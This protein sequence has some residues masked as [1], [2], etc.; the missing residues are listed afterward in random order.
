MDPNTHHT[1][2]LLLVQLLVI[3]WY[4]QNMPD[5]MDFHLNKCMTNTNPSNVI[6]WYPHLHT[7]PTS[8][9]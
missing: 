4:D 6:Q 1:E 2:Q 3:E 5:C 8:E 9:V 7:I